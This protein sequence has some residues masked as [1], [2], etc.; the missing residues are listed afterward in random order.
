IGRDW[1]VQPMTQVH[2]CVRLLAPAD[3]HIGAIRIDATDAVELAVVGV[4][5]TATGPEGPF[6]CTFL[7]LGQHMIYVGAFGAAALILPADVSLEVAMGQEIVLDLHLVNPGADPLT[8][9]TAVKARSLP[10]PRAQ[11]AEAVFA[12]TFQIN[13]PPQAPLTVTGSCTLA[14]G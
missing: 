13:L 7:D 11:Q 2:Q 8:G 14:A 10:A 4:N 6:D 3:V 1:T 12:G 9:H 5:D